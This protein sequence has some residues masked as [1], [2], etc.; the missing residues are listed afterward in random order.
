MR[1]QKFPCPRDRSV[2]EHRDDG[3]DRQVFWLSALAARF[4]FPRFPTVAFEP[5]LTDYSGGP[6]PDSHRLP[7][8]S[9]H[10]HPRGVYD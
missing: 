2:P 6:A 1:A 7:F 3:H 4:A 9:H 10:T 5:S 8:S